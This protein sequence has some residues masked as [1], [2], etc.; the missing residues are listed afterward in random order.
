MRHYNAVASFHRVWVSLNPQRAPPTAPLSTRKRL[1]ISSDSILLAW[2]TSS[3]ELSMKADATAADRKLLFRRRMLL[4][5]R[6]LFSAAVRPQ[7]LARRRTTSSRCDL[8]VTQM[9]T[10]LSIANN[11]RQ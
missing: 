9:E 8:S 10:A 6:L 7:L 11:A 2:A 4:E 5:S 3:R 1:Q